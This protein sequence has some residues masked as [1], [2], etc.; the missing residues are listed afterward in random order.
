MAF[1]FSLEFLLRLRASQERQEQAR[2]QLAAQ[3]MHAAQARCASL[4]SERIELESKF[5]VTLQA[6]MAASEMYFHLSARAGLDSAE[7]EAKRTLA[8]TCKHWNEQRARFIQSRRN[9][10]VISSVRDRQLHEYLID[11]ARREQQQ[12]DDLFAMRRINQNG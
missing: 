11:Q 3:R 2:L 10:E 5:R 6:G 9:R 4:A 1:S 12:I 8:E 7:A